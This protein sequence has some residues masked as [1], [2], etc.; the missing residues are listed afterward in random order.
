MKTLSII[1]YLRIEKAKHLLV[2]TDLS[3]K[4]IASSGCT[5]YQLHPLLTGCRGRVNIEDDRVIR[6]KISGILY[7]T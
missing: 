2:S 3:I 6:I 5:M 4:N 7:S 1:T